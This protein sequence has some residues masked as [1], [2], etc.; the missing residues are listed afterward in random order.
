MKH[1]LN[2]H[3]TRSR[4]ILSLAGQVGSAN[5]LGELQCTISVVTKLTLLHT[6]EYRVFTEKDGKVVSPFHDI[7]LFANEDRTVSLCSQL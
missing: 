6:T 4:S 7:P 2:S 1:G 5:T 3:L